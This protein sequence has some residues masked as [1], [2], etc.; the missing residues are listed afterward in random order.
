MKEGTIQYVSGPHAV[1]VAYSDGTF[2]TGSLKVSADGTV[3]F[4]PTVIKPMEP[5]PA[6]KD[7]RQ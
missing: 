5:K 7:G 3:R 1:G 4:E 6:T 2:K